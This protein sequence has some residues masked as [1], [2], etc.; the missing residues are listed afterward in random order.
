MTLHREGKKILFG[1]LIAFIAII[2]LSETFIEWYWLRAII[3]AICLVFYILF[4]QFFRH[5][6]RK[7]TI[8]EDI[9][10]CPA[11]GKLVV[12]EEVV[13]TEVLNKKVRQLSVFMSPLNVHVN[14]YPVAGE[15]TFSKHHHG[16]FLVAWHPKSSEENERTTVVVDNP[17]WGRILHRQIAGA[18]AR[19]I[20]N[21]AKVGD[22][23]GQGQESGFIKFGSRVDIFIPLEAEVLVGIN[24]VVKGGVTP[25]AR[26]K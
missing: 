21:Y 20:V 23:V 13:E 15:V 5:P 18:V 12:I 8:D 16:K 4:L 14:R 22:K 10:L 25:L 11:D 26:L 9:I 6:N 17:K 19:R 2:Y 7:L 3:I 24:E 1:A